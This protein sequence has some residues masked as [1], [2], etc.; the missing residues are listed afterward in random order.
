MKVD[1]TNESEEI[2]EQIEK[3][4]RAGIPIY[5]IFTPDGERDLLPE[6]ITTELLS[7]AL[8]RASKAHPPEQFLQVQGAQPVACV[9]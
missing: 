7:E 3:L 4:G 1:F 8:Q 6:V 5:V 9:K 2:E